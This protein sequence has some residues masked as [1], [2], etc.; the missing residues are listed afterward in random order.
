MRFIK[1]LLNDPL[2]TDICINGCTGVFVDRGE[3]L[4]LFCNPGFTPE[5]LKSWALDLISEAGKS[6]DAKHPFVDGVI[7]PNH[8]L[9]IAFPP[10]AG[11]GILV[12]IRKLPERRNENRWKNSSGFEIL[13]K[14]VIRGESMIVS[15]ATG[16]GKTTLVN[17]LLGVV[18]PNERILALED[19]PELAPCHPHFIRLNSR[20]A[21]A[22][23]F[24]EV[25]IRALL[26]QALRMRPDRI[27]LGECRGGEVLDL[28]QTLNTGH[29]GALAT[30]HANSPRDALRRIELLCLLGSG[31][32]LSTSTIR[33]LLANGIQWLVHTQ[34]IGKDRQIHEITKIEG[35]EKDTILLRPLINIGNDR[36]TEQ[37]RIAAPRSDSA[38][39][40][41][42]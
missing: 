30:L 12:S 6:W 18:S 29:H 13:E 34:R 42:L 20:A 40:V 10:V 9:H 11:P 26:R 16:S 22:D 41:S 3:G 2:I 15:G 21:N 32:N 24:G 4:Q 38:Y 36:S 19:T 8:R 31:A 14:A 27:I 1:P 28:L 7:H 23:G 17:D 25:S 35:R 37:P 5:T 39:I 33:E